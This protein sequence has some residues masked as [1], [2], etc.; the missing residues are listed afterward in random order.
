MMCVPFAAT[1]RNQPLLMRSAQSVRGMMSLETFQN[2]DD[3]RMSTDVGSL[4]E[5]SWK[6]EELGFVHGL[7]DHDDNTT[8]A[9]YLT[10]PCIGDGLGHYDVTA[11][12]SSPLRSNHQSFLSCRLIRCL[13]ILCHSY[14]EIIQLFRVVLVLMILLK[15]MNEIPFRFS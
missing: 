9:G 4:W 3:W 13:Q 14:A 8:G 6:A 11:S 12:L 5:L 2:V 10:S 1:S 7:D 15:L